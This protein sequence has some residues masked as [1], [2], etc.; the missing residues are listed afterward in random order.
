MEALL[1]R[2]VPGLSKEW[3]GA[4][5]DEI[6]RIE[7]LAGRALPPFYRWF[8]S[9]MG[10]SMGRLA[11][12]TL[13]F[14]ASRVLA[15][16]GEKLVA[17]EPRFFLIA[18]ES[19]EAMPLHLFYDLEA[20]ARSDALV[21]SRDA[22]GNEQHDGFETLREM[23]AWG[24]W[25]QFRVGTLPQQCEGMIT[26]DPAGLL[27]RLDPVMS[28][29]GFTQPIPTGPYCR[30]YERADAAMLCKSPP[31]EDFE[32]SQVF[33]LG[34]A[35]AGTLRRI[36]GEIATEPSLEVEVDEWKPKLD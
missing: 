24:A 21:T 17:P 32:G 1:L 12:P 28:R 30:L 11:Y 16:Y 36:L 35:N 5:P 19:D 18:H 31:S 7:Q 22:Q 6:A 15:C 34:G 3:Q 9:R 23:L 29:L 8:L 27:S 26:G 25:L 33:T 13:D 14:S 2:I 20:P 4:T 10:R